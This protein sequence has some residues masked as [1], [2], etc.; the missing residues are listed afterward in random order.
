[1]YFLHEWRGFIPL[2]FGQKSIR[3]LAKL[4]K[5]S[6]KYIFKCTLLKEA[7]SLILELLPE[8]CNDKFLTEFPIK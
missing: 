7:I 8:L 1:F 5:L 4:L 3:K 6:K 2:F